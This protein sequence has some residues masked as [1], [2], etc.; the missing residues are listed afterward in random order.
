[1]DNIFTSLFTSNQGI[2]YCL[3]QISLLIKKKSVFELVFKWLNH[4]NWFVNNYILI[5]LLLFNS[6]SE[7][8]LEMFSNTL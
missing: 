7:C 1:M 3:E 6:L 5:S 4:S 2:F 8:S